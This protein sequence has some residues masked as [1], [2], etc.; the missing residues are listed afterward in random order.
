MLKA[1]TWLALNPANCDALSA[2][3]CE[4][5][6]AAEAKPILVYTEAKKKEPASAG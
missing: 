4:A 6:N 5:V 1:A 2:A 3:T